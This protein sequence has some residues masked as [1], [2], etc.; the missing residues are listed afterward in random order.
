MCEFVCMCDHEKDFMYKIISSFCGKTLSN[1][2]VVD[3]NIKQGIHWRISQ[4]QARSRL[5]QAIAG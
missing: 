2:Y 4:N 5:C 1:N 3:E